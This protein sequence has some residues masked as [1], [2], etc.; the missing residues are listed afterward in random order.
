MIGKLTGLVDSAGEDW[1]VI[2]VAGVGY[3][4]FCSR[5]TLER[6]RP[7]SGPVALLVETHVR[8]DHIHLFGFIDAAERDWFRLL[9]TVQG[10][11]A[12]MALAIL[13]VLAPQDLIQAIAAQDKAQLTRAS[14]VGPKLAGR[15]LAELKD[16]AGGLALGPS[17]LRVG[18]SADGGG[19]GPAA[20]DAVSA[21]VN[22]GYGRSEA[23]GAVARASRDLGDGA[24]LESL[25]KAGLK[26]LS[27]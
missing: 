4:V 7:G 19:L 23:F 26:E 12:R 24:A 2:D 14:G 13:S 8:E 3:H 10:V 20:G 27:A 22:L 6:L 18:A 1:A 21:L 9:G 16:K 25:V 17:A 11:G 5:R 15:I